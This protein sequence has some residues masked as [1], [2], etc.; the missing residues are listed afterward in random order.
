MWAVPHEF[1]GKVVFAV[2]DATGN[3]ASCVANNVDVE[4][5]SQVMLMK[6]YL[7]FN[8]A[9]DC[10]IFLG[11]HRKVMSFV[12]PLNCCEEE[13]FGG[14][15]ASFGVGREIANGMPNLSLALEG[16]F[17]IHDGVFGDLTEFAVAAASASGRR[18]DKVEMDCVRHGYCLRRATGRAAGLLPEFGG[19]GVL[20]VVGDGDGGGRQDADRRLEL[21]LAPARMLQRAVPAG[22]VACHWYELSSCNDAEYTSFWKPQLKSE[23]FYLW[24][25][26]CRSQVSESEGLVDDASDCEIPLRFA[27]DLGLQCTRKPLLWRCLSGFLS[28][29]GGLVAIQSVAKAAVA[30]T[31]HSVHVGE[32]RLQRNM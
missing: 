6:L 29:E 28:D 27:W 4:S 31:A 9:C 7:L 21:A 26:S 11:G 10:G 16:K 24:S 25:E 1:V 13:F 18:W 20:L 17:R 2:N 32:S 23:E 12:P 3:A 19:G 8:E 30:K 5:V 14:V 22:R 15:K